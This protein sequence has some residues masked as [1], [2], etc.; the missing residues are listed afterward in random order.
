MK[1]FIMQTSPASCHVL[2]T[3]LSNTPTV[4]VCSTQIVRDQVSLPYKTTD[5]VMFLDAQ[6]EL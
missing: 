6:S 2:N 1:L 3:L 4:F 5:K